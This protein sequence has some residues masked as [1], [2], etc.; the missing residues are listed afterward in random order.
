MVS[1][2]KMR[3]RRFTSVFVFH[4]QIFAMNL[5]FLANAA[6]ASTAVLTS[7]AAII[8]V[9]I[10]LFLVGSY[11]LH[12]RRP[13]PLKNAVCVVTGGSSGIGYCI[14]KDLIDRGAASV[15]IIARSL[16]KLE[17]S[18]ASLK[19]YALSSGSSCEVRT[20]ALD[21]SEE[22]PKE[23]IDLLSS[24]T[25]LFLCAGSALART[26]ITAGPSSFPRMMSSNYHTAASL[27]SLLLPHM[28]GRETSI[29]ITSSC[30]GQVGIYGYTAYSGSK[31][32]L[33]GLADALR[34]E[35]R[36]SG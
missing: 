25:H 14:C 8:C 9:V 23:S 33:K 7:P 34:L 16:D 20:M 35:V 15:T 22:V 12:P 31:F 30:A 4:L 18:K 6:A 1:L 17:S 36:V 29:L 21:L 24:V 19:E 3:E 26:C 28:V 32:A 13:R 27:I 2:K 11:A 10:V 5:H